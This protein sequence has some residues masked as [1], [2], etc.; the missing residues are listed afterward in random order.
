MPES[1]VIRRLRDQTRLLKENADRAQWVYRE[2]LAELNAALLT[3]P[4]AA[5]GFHGTDDHVWK[6]TW[7]IMGSRWEACT[8]GATRTGR[9]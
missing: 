8:C 6:P 5:P 3:Q 1:D 4:D 7:D 2:C 9:L